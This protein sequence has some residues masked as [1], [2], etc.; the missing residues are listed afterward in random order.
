MQRALGIGR[1][2]RAWRDRSLYSPDISSHQ[3]QA[4]RN[5]HFAEVPGSAMRGVNADLLPE[6]MFSPEF[7][8]RCRYAT[9][10]IED[11]LPHYKDTPARFNGSDELM[12]W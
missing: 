2:S 8:I 10:P 3:V 7:H 9:T 1:N 5:I 4:L 12:Q 11:A 6:G